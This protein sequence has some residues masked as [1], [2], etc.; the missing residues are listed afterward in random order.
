MA[1]KMVAATGKKTE[2]SAAEHRILGVMIVVIN[3]RLAADG[4]AGLAR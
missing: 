3:G 4:G 2:I 1:S